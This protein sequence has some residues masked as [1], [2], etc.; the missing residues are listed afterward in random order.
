VR[1]NPKREGLLKALAMHRRAKRLDTDNLGMGVH[2]NALERPS[3][4]TE[5]VH[6]PAIS[7]WLLSTKWTLTM[8]GV[9]QVGKAAM[10]GGITHLHGVDA[11]GDSPFEAVPP[12]VGVDAEVVDAAVQGGEPSRIGCVQPDSGSGSSGGNAGAR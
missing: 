12:V 8:V 11:H 3:K 1:L 4:Q 5:Q 7:A 9:M 6:K 2:A 10:Q